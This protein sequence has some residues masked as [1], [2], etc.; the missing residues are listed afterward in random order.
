M[1]LYHIVL[2]KFKKDTQPEDLEKLASLSGAM[3]GEVSGLVDMKTGPPLAATSIRAKGFEYAAVATLEGVQF[4][5]GYVKN[6]IHGEL[7]ALVGKI[8]DETVAFDLEF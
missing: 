2:F 3:I 5:E 1:G 8:A 6:P 4:L 7:I